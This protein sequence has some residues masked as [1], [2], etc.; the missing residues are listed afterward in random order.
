MSNR[1]SE[2]LGLAV[3]IQLLS[4]RLFQFL[5]LAAHDMALVRRYQGMLL[6]AIQQESDGHPDSLQKYNLVSQALHNFPHGRENTHA[7]GT[8]QSR[9][10][11]TLL[12]A[13]IDADHAHDN[14]VLL[15]HAGQQHYRQHLSPLW[16]LG[17]FYQYIDQ[18]AA[19]ITQ[20]PDIDDSDRPA[21]AA[22]LSKL[23]L[24]DMGL[25]LQGYWEASVLEQTT[26]NSQNT[27]LQQQVD[28]LM[29]NIPQV[30]WS[31]DVQSN[32]ALYVS[33]NVY[34][35]CPLDVQ[36]PIPCL[37]W[38]HPDDLAPVQEAWEWAMRGEASEIESRIYSSDK[39]IR[40]FRRLFRPY[41]DT[42][43]NVVR[44]DGIMEETTDTHNAILRLE[45]LAT[46]DPLTQLANR[47]LWHDRLGQAIHTARRE[48]DQRIV[49][50]M[51]DLN[52]FKLINDALGHASGDN[53]LRE[54]AKRL[55]TALREAD[56]LARLGGDEFGVLL[57]NNSDPWAAAE[58]VAGKILQCF[59]TA[60]PS[61]QEELFL[62]AAIGIAVYPEDG[63]DVSNLVSHSEIAMYRAKRED[64]GYCFYQPTIDHHGI[65][66][67]HL[68]SHLHHALKN[69]EFELHYQPKIDFKGRCVC[70]VEALLR[71]RHPTLGLLEPDRFIP[72]AEQT[73]LITATTEW[74]L[75][76]AL[77]QHRD[78]LH[79]GHNIPISINI[80]ALSF[81]N[82]NLVDKISNALDWAG[83]APSCLEIEITEN[84]LLKGMNHC[85]ETV[86]ALSNLGIKIAIDDFGIGYSSLSYLR[87]LPIDTL[88]IDKSF[89]QEM[90]NNHS[91][92][93]IT[94]SII[95]L[96]HNLGF[97][98][99]AEGVETE[100][101]Y[102]L[103]NQQ[104]CDIAQG[105][106]ISSPQ[107]Q[108]PFTHW[109]GETP[110]AIG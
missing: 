48:G 57:S 27:L 68:S 43:G 53:I 37:A 4:S 40:W 91:D 52:H 50:M 98:I 12:I 78:W 103:L 39:D 88:K 110:W 105:F 7:A 13:D 64:I 9:Y 97:R 74:V 81:Q 61:G 15:T 44:I 84:T 89:I 73:G 30:L 86:T 72:L 104:H 77:Q 35:I 16:I 79:L 3:N 41:L 51:V 93:V 66:Q 95:D 11:F 101:A 87:K 2:A 94:R 22:T 5:G 80:S 18:V 102:Q 6:D 23:V 14:A 25:V 19:M 70:G 34:D 49:L 90:A 8:Q 17:S 26:Q 46:I 1:H 99:V 71:W 65:E 28:S 62:S 21:L 33:P 42:E 109:L 107:A 75:N 83:V 58:S 45:T 29:A 47:T 106:Y 59:D 60:F 54:S 63:E 20:I 55:K 38:T 10:L 69:E 36:M 85:A 108:A 24:R 92:A 32:R 56:T 67:L 82:P 31:V 96:G 76:T 100:Q